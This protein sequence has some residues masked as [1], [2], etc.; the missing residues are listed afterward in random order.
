MLAYMPKL[1]LSG[2]PNA[3]PSL[4]KGQ[5]TRAEII[6]RSA[7][8]MNRHGFLAL[9]LS[10]VIESTGIQKGGLY[11][12]FDS[13]EALANEAFECC[14]AAVRQRFVEALQGKSTAC[15]QLLA[16]IDAHVDA[17]IDVPLPGGCPIMNSVVETDHTSDPAHA[18][19]RQRARDAM[20]GWHGL[21]QKIVR[22][23]IADGDLRVDV[24][25]AHVASVFIAC[26]EGAVLLTQL[27]GDATHMAAAR[28]HLSSYIDFA[29][30]EKPAPP[31][32][33]VGVRSFGEPP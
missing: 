15:E 11:R 28:A 9:P 22:G 27:Y 18:S 20:S 16:L 12:H 13:R 17:G 29:L 23:G 33:A 7:A 2:A 32:H 19:L 3:G 10:A 5:R 30:R 26:M 8:L 31:S 21:V 1:A 25:P 24:E 4:T 14:V 6:R